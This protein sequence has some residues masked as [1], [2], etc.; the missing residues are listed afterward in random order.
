MPSSFWVG[1]PKRPPSELASRPGYD[2]AL[3][4]LVAANARAV[5]LFPVDVFAEAATVSFSTP[6]SRVTPELL[7]RVCE[8]IVQARE[9][10]SRDETA[11]LKAESDAAKR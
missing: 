6:P 5:R 7:R 2:E 10:A 1:R 4:E 11:A 8:A 9:D 3:A